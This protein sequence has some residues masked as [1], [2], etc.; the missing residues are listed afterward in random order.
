MFNPW[1]YLL[2]SPD[3]EDPTANW[4]EDRSEDSPEHSSEADEKENLTF[5]LFP[6]LPMEI[7]L[8]IIHYAC[9]GPRIIVIQTRV[10]QVALEKYLVHIPLF[11]HFEPRPQMDD[12]SPDYYRANSRYSGVHSWIKNSPVSK[13]DKITNPVWLSVNHVFRTEMLKYYQKSSYRWSHSK[14]T[15]DVTGG[16][17]NTVLRLS[18]RMND[19]QAGKMNTVLR[20]SQRMNDL[21]EGKRLGFSE[22]PENPLVLY[23]DFKRDNFTFLNTLELKY[24][25]SLNPGNTTEL[26]THARHLT[27]RTPI[28]LAMEQGLICLSNFKSLETITLEEPA[29]SRSVYRYEWPM[30]FPCQPP[31]GTWSKCRST[32]CGKKLACSIRVSWQQGTSDC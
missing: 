3:E 19:L 30:S 8:R 26:E 11:E 12:S 24:F 10:R 14:T 7:Q 15:S 16:I 6:K 32:K 27:I 9:P 22:N 5:H 21:Q 4:V 23:C 29:N 20:R 25:M 17:M 18:Q 1:R 2:S 31:P 13:L 28:V